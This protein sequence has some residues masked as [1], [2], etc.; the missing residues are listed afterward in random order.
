[1]SFRPSPRLRRAVP[2]AVA[3]AI[4]AAAGAGAYALTSHGSS[5]SAAPR[6]VVPAQ[7]ASSTS[8][9]DSLTQLYKQDA[10]GIV[11]ITVVSSTSGGSGGFPFG[12]PGSS[13]KQESEGTGFEIDTRGDILTAEHVVANATSIRVQF[14]D[15]STAKASLV[16]SDK[17]TDTA[18]VHVDLPA[19]K[20]H[21]LALG[22]SSSAQPGQSVVAIGSPFGL[23]ESMTAGIVSAT[24][25]TI[26]AP[27]GF[28]IS[29][30]IQTDAAINH[31]NSGGPLIDAA[32]NTVIGINDQ[33][34]SDSNDNAGVGFA[35]PIDAARSVART[36][37]AGG[38][39]KHAYLGV[40]IE[41]VTGGARVT[42]VVGGSPAA[43]GGLKVGDVV[44]GFAG[45]SITSA[46]E[47]TAAVS[48]A[49]SGQTVTVTVRRGGSTK[50][51]H[52][53]LGVQPAS[54]SS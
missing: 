39:V 46:D 43:K 18:V 3:V 21:P 28:S 25:R 35:V 6:V 32:T 38:T 4:G 40:R 5:R 30:A 23:P 48:G 42:Q 24:N 47:L 44:T 36:L 31:G 22:S 27:S 53:T 10:P 17:S 13:Q 45:K 11:D 19:S 16:G 26:T 2:L 1:M 15:G 7:P 49:K 33:I 12:T 34:E 51:L 50:Q 8:T 14:A 41:G 9:V 29:G 52:V 54:P 37:I 20:L